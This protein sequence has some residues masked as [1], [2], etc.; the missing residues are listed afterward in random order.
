MSHQRGAHSAFF[1]LSSTFL[2]FYVVHSNTHPLTAQAAPQGWSDWS[3]SEPTMTSSD[4]LDSRMRV[5]KNFLA[6]TSQELTVRAGDIVHVTAVLDEEWWEVLLNG[7]HGKV[8]AAFLSQIEDVIPEL[9]EGAKD[10]KHKKSKKK[11]SGGKVGEEEEGEEKKLP[12]VEEY[13][14]ASAAA[15]SVS[16]VFVC[17]CVY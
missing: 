9:T 10:K 5:I 8:P 14:A 15:K 6:R 7:K 16:C 2:F 17:T 11:K 13:D 1:F 12:P 4:D 3:P